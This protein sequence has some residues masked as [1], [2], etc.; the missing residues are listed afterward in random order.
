MNNGVGL[1]NLSFIAVV[2]VEPCLGHFILEQ[3]VQWATTYVPHLS[4]EE[5]DFHGYEYFYQDFHLSL[6][7]FQNIPLKITQAI[8]Q[9]WFWEF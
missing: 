4:L 1:Y 8:E 7:E 6:N 2:E 5:A 3:E 9:T